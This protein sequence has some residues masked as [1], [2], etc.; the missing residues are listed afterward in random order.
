MVDHMY[1]TRNIDTGDVKIQGANS[2]EMGQLSQAGI[3]QK[4][5]D[6]LQELGGRP[7]MMPSKPAKPKD[8]LQFKRKR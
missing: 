4:A 5:A 3:V 1:E 2:I 6:K 8:V 7:D